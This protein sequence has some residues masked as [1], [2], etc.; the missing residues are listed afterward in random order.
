MQLQ[1]S[2]GRAVQCSAVQCI[3]DVMSSVISACSPVNWAGRQP[4]MPSVR[5]FLPSLLSAPIQSRRYSDTAG[6]HPEKTGRESRLLCSTVLLLCSLRS[7]ATARGRT[8]TGVKAARRREPGGRTYSTVQ[9]RYTPEQQLS[10][11][12]KIRE[13]GT[14]QGK[15][16]STSIHATLWDGGASKMRIETTC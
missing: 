2:Q 3:C 16:L 12:R 1:L 15:Q 5:V 7:R 11:W 13:R 4:G 8:R 9:S 14:C 10:R 6:R